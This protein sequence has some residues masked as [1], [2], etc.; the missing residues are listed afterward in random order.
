MSDYENKLGDLL[1]AMRI[2]AEACNVGDVRSTK[3]CAR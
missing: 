3:R 1:W 2:R